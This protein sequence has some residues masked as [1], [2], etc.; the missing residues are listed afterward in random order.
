MA[1]VSLTSKVS[2]DAH[3]SPIHQC[4]HV[5]LPACAYLETSPI[6]EEKI[7]WQQSQSIVFANICF[8]GAA[9]PNSPTSMTAPASIGRNVALL[10]GQRMSVVG[11]MAL[12]LCSDH[13][14]GCFQ[15][16]DAVPHSRNNI[17]CYPKP[18]LRC[19]RIPRL[20]FPIPKRDR[21]AGSYS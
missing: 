17:V 12:V 15:S 9:C 2:D 13:Y 18:V 5:R 10:R 19:S 14:K 4:P 16:D 11:S 7:V 21:L 20:G 6:L 1:E 8:S 3:S